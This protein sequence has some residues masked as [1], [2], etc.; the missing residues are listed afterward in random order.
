MPDGNFPG[1][2]Q[3]LV[4]AWAKA[5]VW[6]ATGDREFLADGAGAERGRR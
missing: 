3:S 5:M 1:I 2:S 4:L 6:Q